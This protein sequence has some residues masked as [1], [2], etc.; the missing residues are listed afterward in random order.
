[1]W[2]A[3]LLEAVGK[4]A[5]A[6][7]RHHHR[8]D[9]A[10]VSAT[11]LQALLPLTSSSSYSPASSSSSRASRKATPPLLG[12]RLR[13]GSD[14]VLNGGSEPRLPLAVTEVGRP[15]PSSRLEAARGANG[16]EGV[17]VP[18]SK[19]V[20]SKLSPRLGQYSTVY[21]DVSHL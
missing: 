12:Y 8:I 20:G 9:A 4:E 16:E 13:T 5:A 2:C 19:G 21:Q 3:G 18:P 10:A 15:D 17:K 14:P 7:N 6:A 1:M 11:D